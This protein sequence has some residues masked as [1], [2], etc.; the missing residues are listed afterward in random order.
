MLNR[1]LS[2]AL[3]LAFCLAP[4]SLRPQTPAETPGTPAGTMLLTIFLRHDES[5]TLDAINAHLRQTGL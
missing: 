3:L 1:M 5:K 2:L 4:V